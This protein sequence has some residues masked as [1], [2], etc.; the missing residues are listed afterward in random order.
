MTHAYSVI[1]V[2]HHE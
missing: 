1:E 2:I